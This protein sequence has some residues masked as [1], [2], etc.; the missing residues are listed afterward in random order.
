[1]FSRWAGMASR[2]ATAPMPNAAIRTTVSS[3]FSLARPFLITLA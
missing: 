1:M 2:I 3:D